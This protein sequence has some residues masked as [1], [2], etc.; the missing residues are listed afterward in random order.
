MNDRQAASTER[1]TTVTSK[2]RLSFNMAPATLVPQQAEA[3][4][5]SFGVDE[6]KYNDTCSEQ[7]ALA[8][9]GLSSSGLSEE[10]SKSY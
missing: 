2:T 1:L 5:S 6:C 10:P 9:K 7:H 3:H 4:S 8:P